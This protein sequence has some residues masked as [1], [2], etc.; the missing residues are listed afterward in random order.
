MS[1]VTSGSGP[2]VMLSALVTTCYW[3]CLPLHSWCRI[4]VSVSS[5]Q[6]PRPGS[7]SDS[8]LTGVCSPWGRWDPGPD[9]GARGAPQCDAPARPGS[10]PRAPRL[11]TLA[12]PRPGQARPGPGWKLCW[13]QQTNVSQDWEMTAR[14]SRDLGPARLAQPK[15]R[16]WGAHH[17]SSS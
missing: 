4:T 6:S 8:A 3:G 12:P 15:L 9:T 17:S 14:Q 5:V 2:G 1:L 16:L 13:L 11:V 10:Q 7:D